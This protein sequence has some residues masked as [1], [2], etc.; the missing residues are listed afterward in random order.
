MANAAGLDFEPMST[1]QPPTGN[2]P[3]GEKRSKSGQFPAMV[4]PTGGLVASAERPAS[5]PPQS[6]ELDSEWDKSEATAHV[7]PTT[8]G[9]VSAPPRMPS[10][11]H[12]SGQQRN[13]QSMASASSPPKGRF[14]VGN[15]LNTAQG[16]GSN[17][18]KR[19]DSAHPTQEHRR[20]I[21]TLPQKALERNSVPSP[22][23]VSAA[24]PLPLVK[25]ESWQSIVHNAPT[26]NPESAVRRD[27]PKGIGA[28]FIA[29]P[30]A[31]I[32][33][34]A[35]LAETPKGIGSCAV[36]APPAPISEPAAITETP[37]GIGAALIAAPPTPISEPAA[38]TET[39][40]GIGS[41]AVAAS[42]APIPE[43]A[44]I[45]ETPEPIGTAVAVRPM[46]IVGARAVA[47]ESTSPPTSSEPA[48]ASEMSRAA[49]QVLK[50]SPREEAPVPI[51][52]E[53]AATP[54]IP[55]DV[56]HSMR[57]KL[58][59]A[60]DASLAPQPPPTREGLDDPDGWDVSVDAAPVTKPAAAAQPSPEG[61]IPSAAT[62]GAANANAPPESTARHTGEGK[63]RSG[64][65]QSNPATAKR[66]AKSDSKIAQA[67]SEGFETELSGEFFA[68]EVHDVAHVEHLHEAEDTVDARHLRAI[69]PEAMAR[70]AKFRVLVLVVCVGFVLLLAAA[71]ALRFLHRH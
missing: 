16:A 44:V 34:P 1:G 41:S 63:P 21:G 68:V 56:E 24:P 40:K 37:K 19:I 4:E 65:S 55:T 59:S 14:T 51:A 22:K 52:L 64:G 47:A 70:R 2:A 36:A 13:P 53:V 17:A 57:A 58:P 61:S 48:A 7:A 66:S 15:L 62:T 54:E 29:A 31:P 35:A 49:E 46:P 8:P 25:R 30:P 20:Q 11:P 3:G 12:A 27:T 6:P 28:A 18:P 43:P 39:P 69:S 42:P 9:G 50:V 23:A 32:S 71:I 60:A 5:V 45:A 67:H 26:Q 10:F 38:I 33:E